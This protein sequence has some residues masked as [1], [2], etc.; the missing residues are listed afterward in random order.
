MKNLQAG[1]Q[2]HE[3]F[4]RKIEVTPEM[5]TKYDDVD[6]NSEEEKKGKKR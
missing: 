6:V 5:Q 1:P 2:P 4:Q 3:K